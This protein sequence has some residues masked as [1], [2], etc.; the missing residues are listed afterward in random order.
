M[1]E[2]VWSRLAE[3]QLRRA[4][5]Y[6]EAEQGTFY[7]RLV[8]EKIFEAVETLENY[9][10]AGQR[11]TLLLHKKHIYRYIIAWSYKIIYKV[12]PKRIL[13]AR[14]FHTSQRPTKLIRPSAK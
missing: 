4:V 1:V 11:E 13:I 6:I 14:V 8:T 5:Q 12:G 7:A 3:D 9:P 2:I 10:N